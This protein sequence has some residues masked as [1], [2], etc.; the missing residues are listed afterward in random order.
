[1]SSLNTF[2]LL[3]AGNQEGGWEGVT[4][5]VPSLSTTEHEFVKLLMSPGIDYKESIPPSYLGA[6]SVCAK[7]KFS[8]KKLLKTP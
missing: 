7:T 2:L 4:P 3:S 5:T 8:E 1:M 6:H